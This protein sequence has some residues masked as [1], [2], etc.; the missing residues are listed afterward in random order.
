[1]YFILEQMILYTEPWF[2]FIYLSLIK[3]FQLFYKRVLLAVNYFWL[4]VYQ[5]WKYDGVW[6]CRL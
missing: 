4:R 1:L 5:F 6:W 2:W 3:L